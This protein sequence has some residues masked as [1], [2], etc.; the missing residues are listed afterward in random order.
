MS[1]EIWQ[2]MQMG[3]WAIGIQTTILIALLGVIWSSI[4][5]KF[6]SIDK[7]FTDRC[8]NIEKKIDKMDEKL[9]DIDRRVCRIEGAMNNKDCCMLKSDQQIRKAE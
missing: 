1:E 4:S 3:M 6:D 2:L 7:K 9:T 8:D 5:R